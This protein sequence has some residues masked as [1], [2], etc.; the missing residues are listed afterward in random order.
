MREK[1]HQRDIR[2]LEEVK[3]TWARRKDLVSE[4]HPSTITDHIAR[5]NYI[6][7]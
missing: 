7:D 4:L 2:S 6:I 1:E 3:F 5:N